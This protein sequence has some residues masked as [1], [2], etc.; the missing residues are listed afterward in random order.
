MRE[1]A[2]RQNIPN[3]FNPTTGIS[4]DVP[5][6]GATVSI[7]IYD[8]SGRTVRTLVDGWRPGGTHRVTWDGRDAAGNAVSSGVYFYRMAAGSFVE[9]RR[10]VLLK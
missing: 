8:V 7:R 2:L 5:Q 10:M 3:P 9:A 1:F 4:Y 6:G